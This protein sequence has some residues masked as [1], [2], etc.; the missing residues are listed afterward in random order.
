[1]RVDVSENVFCKLVKVNAKSVVFDVYKK[2]ELVDT[3]EYFDINK[4]DLQQVK[5]S[6]KNQFRNL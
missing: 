1:M 5:Q 6:M 2:G 3:K 4:I